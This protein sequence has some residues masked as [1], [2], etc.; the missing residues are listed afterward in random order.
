MHHECDDRSTRWTN[1]LFPGT[2]E[3]RTTDVDLTV[4]EHVGV[5]FA[6]WS[7]FDWSVYGVNIN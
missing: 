2:L 7:Y 4:D 3:F 5:L 6:C 1:F